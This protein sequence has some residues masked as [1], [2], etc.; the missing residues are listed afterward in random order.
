MVNGFMSSNGVAGVTR[1]EI[2]VV[3]GPVV[4]THT[5]VV[6]KHVYGV[7]GSGSGGEGT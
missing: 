3:F 7:G 6:G 2:R 5:P 4:S 1:Y